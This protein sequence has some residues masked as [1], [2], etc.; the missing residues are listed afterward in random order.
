MPLIRILSLLGAGLLSVNVWAAGPSAV[1]DALLADPQI[2]LGISFDQ[3]AEPDVSPR[4][5]SA[6][7][8]G[9]GSFVPGVTGG[10]LSFEGT[11]SSY[12]S[13]PISSDLDLK[14]GS[15]MMWFRPAW[16]GQE[17]EGQY[18]LLWVTMTGSEKYFAIH[19]SFNPQDKKALYVNLH[20]DNVLQVSTEGPFEAGDWLH[21]AVT[22]SAA[23]N[24]YILYFNAVKVA[25]GPWKDMSTEKEYA[26]S[27]LILGEYYHGEGGD[28]PI[29][30][31]YDDLFI[32][33]RALSAG[34]IENYYKSCL[35][36]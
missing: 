18:T 23:K 15:I 21:I 4:G 33:K 3:S 5:I 32:F 9:V 8:T 20:W 30:G 34:E 29:N 19:R 35:R 16:S 2:V 36:M 27:D 13:Y 6:R 17:A 24:E 7:M 28:S 26:P 31:S 11:D 22:W 14:E 12:V 1:R 10:C 25:E